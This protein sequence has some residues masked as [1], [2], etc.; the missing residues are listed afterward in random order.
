M[1]SAKRMI[2]SPLIDNAQSNIFKKYS[3]QNACTMTALGKNSCSLLF[4]RLI[5][6]SIPLLTY[7]LHIICTMTLQTWTARSET[8]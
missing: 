5:L 8:A 6:F 4:L 3:V 2:C 1:T 7:T